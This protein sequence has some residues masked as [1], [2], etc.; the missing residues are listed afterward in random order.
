MTNYILVGNPNTGKTTFYNNLTKSNEHIGNWHGVTV[1]SKQKSFVANGQKYN[2]VDLPGLYSLTPLSLEEKVSVDYIFSHTQDVIINIVDIDNITR[3]LFLTADLLNFG[4]KIILVINKTSKRPDNDIDVTKLQKQLNVPVFLLDASNKKQVKNFKEKLSD[5]KFPENYSQIFTQK[6]DYENI[7]I[8][9]IK[10]IVSISTKYSNKTNF[11]V[12]K[13]LENDQNIF[14]YLNLSEENYKIIKNSQ[15]ALQLNDFEQNSISKTH[16]KIKEISDISI[17][18]VSKKSKINLDK[19]LL[20]KFLCFPI[21]LGIIIL[22]FYLTF[23]SLGAFL[24]EKLRFLIENIFGSFLTGAISKI[25]A[26]QIILSFWQNAI[27]GGIGSLVGFLP[28]VVLLFLF[29]G[30]LEDSG[31]LSRIAFM[32]DDMFSKFGLSGKAVYTLL[33]GFGCG[34]TATLTARNMENKNSKIKTALL[35]PYMSCSAKL[36][37]YAVIGGAFFGAGN[38]FVIFGLYLLGV[39]VALILSVLLDKFALKSSEQSFVLEF[40]KYR[41]PSAK[42]LGFLVWDNLKQFLIRIGSLLI[43]VNIIIWVLCSFSFK[44]HFVETTGEVSILES[45]GKILAP[46][47]VPLG[48]GSWGATSALIAGLIAKEIIVSSIAMFNNVASTNDNNKLISKSLTDPSSAVFF[49]PAGAMSYLVF[50]LLYMPC[51]ANMIMLKKE[52]GKKWFLI[53]I[54]IQFSVAYIISL[55]VYNSYRFVQIYGALALILIFIMILLVTFAVYKSVSI[56]KS[57][58]CIGC[59]K[60]CKKAR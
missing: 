54:L 29:L 46:I 49:T 3:N 28:Q 23:F 57:R 8:K 25:T 7:Y 19:I 4:A 15:N 42:R 52:V 47:F 27:V 10:N 40:P 55:V 6:I 31:Y 16:E 18:K 53:S 59:K 48:F 9:N 30:I 11:I 38:V 35:T 2:L 39:V 43:S 24:S 32:F 21:F 5:I 20:N 51:V 14:E 12:Q 34:T 36:P 56:F 60:C 41:F 45:L 58:R 22:I 33:M 44:L 1:D 37:I 13:I 26:N 17:K 50:C